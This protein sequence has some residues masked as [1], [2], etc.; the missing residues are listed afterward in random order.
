MKLNSQYIHMTLELLDEEK[1]KDYKIL[2]RDIEAVDKG[3]LQLFVLQLWKAFQQRQED[4]AQLNEYN[5]ELQEKYNNLCDKLE[6]E[7]RWD[8]RT[9]D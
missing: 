8:P 9:Q 6:Y 7:E 4:I 5:I 1:I 2:V 3:D